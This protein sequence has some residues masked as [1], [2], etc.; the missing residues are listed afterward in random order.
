[1]LRPTISTATGVPRRGWAR[2]FGLLLLLPVLASLAGCRDAPFVP[3]WTPPEPPPPV[4]PRIAFVSNRDG[5]PEIYSMREDGSEV[6]RLTDHPAR[7]QSPA[8][9]PDRRWIA[10]VS[11][12]DGEEQ[13]Y[14]MRFDGRGVRRLTTGAGPNRSPAWSPDGQQIAFVSERDGNEE[15]YRMDPD[16]SSVTRLTDDTGRDFDPAWSPDGSKIAFA[17]K[18]EGTDAI[19]VMDADGGRVIR[20]SMPGAG[21]PEFAPDWSP[22]GMRIVFASGYTGKA[23]PGYSGPQISVMNA[24][25][26]GRRGLTGGTLAHAFSPRWSPDGGRIVFASHRQ[27]T[28]EVYAMS[29][30]G[31]LITKLTQSPRASYGNDQAIS[32]P[33]G[34]L[35]AFVSDRE[36]VEQIYVMSSDGSDVRRLTSGAGTYRL[37]RWSRDGTRIAFQRTQDGITD[38]FVVAAD[39][40]GLLNLSNHP[41]DDIN[42]IWSPD[43]RRIAFTSQRDGNAEIY[44]VSVDGTGLTRLTDHPARDLAEDWSPDGSKIVFLTRRFHQA[45][46]DTTYNDVAVMNTDGTGIVRVSRF[47]NPRNRTPRWSPYGSWIAY[48]ESWD[49]GSSFPPPYAYNLIGAGADGGNH[50]RL[51][52]GLFYGADGLSWS[53]DGSRIAFFTVPRTASRPAYTPGS[54]FVADA[55]GP[56]HQEEMLGKDHLA[57]DR[58]PSWTPDGARLVFTRVIEFPYVHLP[59]VFTSRP[60]G[61]ATIR[62]THGTP[63]SAEPAWSR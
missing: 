30:L 2:D 21:L 18:R 62:L 55:S 58:F 26:T 14:V 12:R 32:S 39:G 22:D 24:D 29:P 7:E 16:G 19:F 49:A 43:G 31:H 59:E 37:S 8:W 48:L 51:T 47:S 46:T 35:I 6:R 9:S 41:A 50:T 10:F 53:P 28:M 63:F 40:S 33:D 61:T 54:I 17:S 13:I 20:L 27:G 56:L 44:V 42:P 52:H 25:G 36:G 4:E 57:S 34:R 3:P 45:S 15:I 38:V 23:Y 5:N 1:M 11:D 60:D